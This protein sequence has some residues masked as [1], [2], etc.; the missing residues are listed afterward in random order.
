[1]H[2][3]AMPQIL[4]DPRYYKFLICFSK[5]SRRMLKEPTIPLIEFIN[6]WKGPNFFNSLQEIRN[7]RPKLTTYLMRLGSD[8]TLPNESSFQQQWWT[9]LLQR[10]ILTPRNKKKTRG[11]QH[12]Y[13]LINLIKINNGKAKNKKGGP[14]KKN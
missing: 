4:G 3:P 12:D 14:K 10:S 6:I 13:K 11:I 7:L 2:S 1:M 8:T 9:T 5:A